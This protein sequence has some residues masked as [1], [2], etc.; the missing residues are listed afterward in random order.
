MFSTTGNRIV[1]LVFLGSVSTSL[2]LFL[3][4]DFLK[5]VAVLSNTS[6][7]LLSVRYILANIRRINLLKA[8]LLL[9][10]LSFYP[11]SRIVFDD[12]SAISIKNITDGYLV[13]CYYQLPIMALALSMCYIRNSD[14]V[15]LDLLFNYVVFFFGVALSIAAL[16]YQLQDEVS[17]GYGYLSYANCFIPVSVLVY[18]QFKRYNL[19]LGFLSII[20]IILFAAVQNSRS[21][22]LVGSYLLIAAIA[23]TYHKSKVNFLLIIF[24]IVV[25]YGFGLTSLFTENKAN[26]SKSVSEKFDFDSLVVVLN[27]S[28]STGD[29]TRIFYWE[30]NSRSQILIDAFGNFSNIDWLVGKGVF[31]KYM[32]FVERSTIELG[33]AQECFRFGIFYV[34]LVISVFIITYGFFTLNKRLLNDPGYKFLSV[35]LLVRFADGFVYGVSEYSVYNLLVFWAVMLQV[36]KR[37]YISIPN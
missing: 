29:F 15:R 33:W 1:F 14:M 23:F 9:S 3:S 11:L 10:V 6:A 21:Y 36:L 24:F 12:M 4:I 22:I 32:S 35:L 19:I 17:V 34:I 2:A 5:Y 7:L 30:G 28:I 27:E 13:S 18:F 26:Q 8:F 31:G 16:K 25:V 20:S 37:K